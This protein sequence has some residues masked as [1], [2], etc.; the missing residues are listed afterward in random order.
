MEVTKDEKNYLELLIKED[1]G[2]G[3]K[4]VGELLKSKKVELATAMIDHP[5]KGNIVLKIKAENPKKE[6]ID[7][8]KSIKDELKKLGAELEG[9]KGK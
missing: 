5:L 1:I 8:I 7:A 2:F 3:N 4:I 6:L 9:K